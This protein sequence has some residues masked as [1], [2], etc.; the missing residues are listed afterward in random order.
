MY[1]RYLDQRLERDPTALA[2]ADTNTARDG[3]HAVKADKVE[4]S[5]SIQ[6]YSDVDGNPQ[7]KVT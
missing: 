4:P 5:R 7:A 6:E 3:R 2:R 1:V